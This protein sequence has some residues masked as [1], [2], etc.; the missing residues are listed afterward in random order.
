[1]RKKFTLNNNISDFIP[2]WKESNKGF[3]D[4]RVTVPS[5]GSDLNL[6]ISIWMPLIRIVIKAVYMV[7]GKN[8][9]HPVRFDAKTFLE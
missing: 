1:M 6:L 7:P 8:A 2:S 5:I 9:T 3:I 4:K